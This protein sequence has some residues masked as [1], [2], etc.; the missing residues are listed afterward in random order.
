MDRE[1]NVIWRFALPSPA[2]STPVIWGGSVFFLTS[3]LAQG[4]LA[5]GYPHRWQKLWQRVIGQNNRD[6][7]QAKSNATAPSPVTDGKHVWAFWAPANWFVSRSMAKLFETNWKTVMA[8]SIL[9][10]W[11]FALATLIATGCICNSSTKMP[12]WCSHWTKSTGNEI[13]KTKLLRT[14]SNVLH[15]YASPIM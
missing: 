3:E 13:W 14:V 7:R 15:S 1:T 6:I 11:G 8:N 5:D 12:N 2:P 10:S 9:S 4:Q